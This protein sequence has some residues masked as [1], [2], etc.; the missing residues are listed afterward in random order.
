MGLRHFHVELVIANEMQ[1]LVIVAAF[2]R[3][4]IQDTHLSMLEHCTAAAPLA[5]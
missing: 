3:V 1:I 4:T 5:Y 2:K